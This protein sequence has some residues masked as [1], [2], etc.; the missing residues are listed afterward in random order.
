M[1]SPVH[2]QTMAITLVGCFVPRQRTDRRSAHT[3]VPENMAKRESD[4]LLG[5]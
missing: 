3:V 5:Y 2:Q 1:P 4:L